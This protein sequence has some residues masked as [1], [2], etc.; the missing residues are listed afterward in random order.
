MIYNATYKFC[1]FTVQIK[2]MIGWGVY[3]IEDDIPTSTFSSF[4]FSSHYNCPRLLKVFH[5]NIGLWFYMWSEKKVRKM[6]QVD[7]KHC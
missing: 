3:P 4:H 1:F 6:G 5:L 7:E 2:G